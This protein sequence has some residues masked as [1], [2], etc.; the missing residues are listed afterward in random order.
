M[1]SQ[2]AW[3]EFWRTGS[4]KNYLNY[5]AECKVNSGEKAYEAEYKGNSNSS[6]PLRRE[7]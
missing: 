5:V 1:K 7:Q 4:V 3:T 2:D 6:E